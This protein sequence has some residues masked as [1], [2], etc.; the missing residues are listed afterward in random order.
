MG[1]LVVYLIRVD[2]NFGQFMLPSAICILGLNSEF[3]W[4]QRT[5]YAEQMKQSRASSSG[6]HEDTARVCGEM[7]GVHREYWR[8]GRLRERA[9]FTGDCDSKTKNVR[10]GQRGKASSTSLS[11][12]I[13]STL[14]CCPHAPL[15]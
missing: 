12:K 4:P 9:V 6:C 1:P 3:V 11:G 13:S 5:M 8:E 10:A 7:L 14:S 2:N 15:C